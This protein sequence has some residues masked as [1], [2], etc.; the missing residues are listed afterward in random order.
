M[1]KYKLNKMGKIKVNTDYNLDKSSLTYGDYWLPP[2]GAIKNRNLNFPN[3]RLNQQNIPSIS[4]KNII[5]PRIPYKKNSY[6]KIWYP[7]MFIDLNYKNASGGYINGN[8]P[9]G[10]YFAQ[11]L[12][13]Y[14]R[15][16]FKEVNFGTTKRHRSPEKQS[17]ETYYVFESEDEYQQIQD[18]LNDP[19]TKKGDYVSYMSNNQMGA[20]IARIIKDRDGNKK[21]GTWKYLYEDYF[22][23]TKRHRSPEKQSYETYF[24]YEWEDEYQRIQDILNDP[25][26]KK[27]DYISYISN[28]QMGAKTARIIKDRDG[29]KKLG[30]WKYLYEDYFGKYKKIPNRITS[31]PKRKT[32]IKY[33]LPKEQKYPVNTKKKCSAAL[34]YARY[35]PDPCKI[36]RCVQ[37]N[38]KK[39]PTVGSRSKLIEDCKKKK[40]RS[41]K[42]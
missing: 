34:S 42:K 41:S 31:S 8:G 15:S 30:T 3:A 35:A 28:N 6:G 2:Y 9:I 16:M 5:N 22:G 26:T 21:L 1:S 12:G 27:G 36:A 37:R 32:T 18:I 7:N 25:D 38:C 13:N 4:L 23:T 40:K 24:I 39:Y 20:K 11:G 17:Y 14:P 19:D 29:N 33:C 10:P